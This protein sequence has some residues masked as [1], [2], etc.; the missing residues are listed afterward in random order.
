MTIV[1]TPNLSKKSMRT[2]TNVIVQQFDGNINPKLV[3]LVVPQSTNSSSSIKMLSS[4]DGLASAL[5]VPT[6]IQLTKTSLVSSIQNEKI[7]SLISSTSINQEQSTSSFDIPID[8]TE[9][10]QSGTDYH[11]STTLPLTPPPPVIDNTNPNV[12]SR[13]SNQ[14]E[15]QEKIN[16]ISTIN[17]KGMRKTND[18]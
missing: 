14:Q 2:D 11:S 5:R 13:S 17:T 7:S 15:E 1:T 9:K 12:L 8:M 18:L 3:K 16:D 10:Q 6:K 4:G